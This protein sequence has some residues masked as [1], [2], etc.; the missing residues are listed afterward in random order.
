MPRTYY[1]CYI[2]LN[3]IVASRAGNNRLV[4]RQSERKT[5]PTLELQALTLGIDVLC[6]MWDSLSGSSCVCPINITEL[7][8][9]ADCM[10]VLHWLNSYCHIS[11]TRC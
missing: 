11:W 3:C 10:I 2:S 8:V 7:K 5:I 4:N 6:D 1:C 9:Y